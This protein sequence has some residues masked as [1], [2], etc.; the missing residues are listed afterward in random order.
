MK[1]WKRCDKQIAG[2]KAKYGLANAEIH[3][4]WI[5]RTYL[6]QSK[7]DGFADLSYAD[8]RSAVMSARTAEV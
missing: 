6:E 1:Y 7:I 4:G 2:I 8:R 3:T 5:K